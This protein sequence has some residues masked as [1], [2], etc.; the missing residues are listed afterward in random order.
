MAATS[1]SDTITSK[2]SA[3][4]KIVPKVTKYKT[5]RKVSNKELEDAISNI[6]QSLRLSLATF[7]SSVDSCNADADKYASSTS[8][9]SRKRLF[10]SSTVQLSTA[11]EKAAT[12][13]DKISKV[14]F[15]NNSK[16]EAHNHENSLS[17]LLVESAKEYTQ[18]TAGD[19][20]TSDG[21]DVICHL[22]GLENIENTSSD[23]DIDDERASNKRSLD[24]MSDSGSLDLQKRSKSTIEITDVLNDTNSIVEKT[25]ESNRIYKR[26]IKDQ[27]L[28]RC[29]PL[30][31]IRKV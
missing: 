21:N 14:F 9:D 25:K 29:N 30:G 18:I 2:I 24:E 10:N 22:E 7:H 12:M 8:F 13:L 31:L 27:I 26:K 28:Q 15:R 1:Q 17:T 6:A 5:R 4:P 16:E 11:C 20:V 3:R 19:K 23:I